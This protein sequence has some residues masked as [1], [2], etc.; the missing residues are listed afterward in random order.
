M[1]SLNLPD[2]RTSCFRYRSGCSCFSELLLAIATVDV[3]CRCCTLA[4]GGGNGVYA[5]VEVEMRMH[6]IRRASRA[7]AIK[8][9]GGEHALRSTKAAGV[10]TTYVKIQKCVGVSSESAHGLDS[11]PINV[12]L[13]L[14]SLTADSWRNRPNPEAPAHGHPSK[15]WHLMYPE[16]AALPLH[17]A[18]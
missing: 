10:F 12:P 18:N 1:A 2:A 13:S 9:Q 3:A 14:A 11:C 7:T 5:P 4:I 8:K 15:D 6:R 17:K 16:P